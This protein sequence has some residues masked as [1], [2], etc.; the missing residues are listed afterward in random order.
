MWLGRQE[1]EVVRVLG[2]GGCLKLEEKRGREGEEVIEEE[3]ALVERDLYDL[4]SEQ[5]TESE[6]GRKMEE[7]IKD[8]NTME[9]REH[10]EHEN[11][12]EFDTSIKNILANKMYELVREDTSVKDKGED[13][14]EDLEDLEDLE[15]VEEE[16]TCPQCGTTTTELLLHIAEVHLEEE[17]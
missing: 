14:L 8:L 12:R 2:M 1:L 13:N 7:V 4:E 5:D 9:E 16:K 11:G 3:E 6:L 17:L 15:N 10:F